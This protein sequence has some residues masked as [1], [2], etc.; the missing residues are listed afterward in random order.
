MPQP[1]VL[2]FI[3]D[4]LRADFLGCLGSPLGATPHTDAFAASG[5]T[6]SQAFCVHSVCM[7]TRASIATG[8]YPHIHGV[9]ANG[10]RLRDSEVTLAQTLSDAGYTT[11]ASGKIHHEP[12]QPYRPLAPS[13]AGPYYGFQEVH[14]SE[15]HLG[16]DYMRFI[17]ERHPDLKD[18]AL[19]R[20]RIPE[21]AHDLTWIT[22]QALGFIERQAGGE[23]PFFCQCSFHE[24][25]P[26]C[27]PPPSY[28][29]LYDPADMT[30]PE[31]RQDDLDRK[32]P[33]Y[34]QCYEGYVANG[35]QPD[36]PTLRRYLASA[37]DQLRFVDHQFGRLLATLEQ[38]G[39]ADNTIVLFT[40]DHG[41]AL[42]DHWQWRHGPFLFDEVIN[43]PQ[44]WRVPK[45]G[46]RPHLKIGSDPIFQVEQVDIMPTLV[47]QCGVA[48]PPGVQGRSLLPLL[49]GE[50]G[51]RGAEAVLIQERHAPDLVARGL[52][53]HL[54][55]QVG[56][57]TPEWK[58]IHY[59]EY[60][61]AG[62]RFG[63]EL[64]DLRN[65]PGEFVN[66][67]PERDYLARRR[68]LEALLMDR[69]AATQDPLPVNEYHY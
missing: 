1:N 41:L 23:R 31:L 16:A 35:R 69:L 63:G 59:T 56:I 42:N 25:I 36:E 27:T 32:P 45:N 29:G 43:V 15:N 18:R 6:F 34:R 46:V 4:G 44:I 28:A 48:I 58:L 67:W 61:D 66:L 20:D 39:V 14:L 12:Q 7:P 38:V 50:D 22:D 19:K 30:V 55:W 17:E 53:E 37:Y 54:V 5:V 68:E 64:Y 11:C 21:E 49:R 2:L 10:V 33:W 24:L 62:D 52:D 3:V 51:V 47:E 13:I 40:A 60:R 57:R 9:W 26:P 65:D 8:R